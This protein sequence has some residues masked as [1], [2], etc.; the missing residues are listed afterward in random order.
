VALLRRPVSRFFV[1]A[2]FLVAVAIATGAAGLAWWLIAL[3]E[4]AAWAAVT[5]ADRMIG[6]ASLPAAVK[7]EEHVA[8]EPTPPEPEPV[9]VVAP[10]WPVEPEPVAASPEP[11]V[12]A[13]PAPASVEEPPRRRGIRRSPVPA[14]A[15]LPR[16]Q[17]RWNVWSLEQLARDHPDAE[18]L[19]FLVI[20]LREFAAADGQ[21]PVDFDP[22]VRESFG[23]LLLG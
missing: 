15:T 6:R 8:P 11:E 14:Q 9:P 5:L 1:W 16:D 7:R 3:V 18:D 12:V 22:L 2:T 21:L 23:E 17:V 13:A 4:F 10:E 19:E 20:S